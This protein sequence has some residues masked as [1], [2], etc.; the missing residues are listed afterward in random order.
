MPMY[1]DATSTAQTAVTYRSCSKLLFSPNS[2]YELAVLENVT[3]LGQKDRSKEG[4][5]VD[6]T[7]D[8]E[9][10]IND[11]KIHGWSCVAVDLDAKEYGSAATRLRTLFI[12]MKGTEKHVAEKMAV[13]IVFCL[14]SAAYL[15]V[16]IG[17]CAQLL[18]LII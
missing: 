2:A 9:Y 5:A 18:H 11:F 13:D 7:S 3:A 4:S 6:G 15:Y 16:W 17:M 12:A 1:R 10:I 8:S 14:R